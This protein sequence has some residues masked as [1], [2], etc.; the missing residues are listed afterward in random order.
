M[1]TK[2]QALTAREFHFTGMHDCIR[3]V[4]PRGGV[5]VNVTVARRNGQTKTW[6]TRPEEFSVPVKY[7]E[8]SWV[9]GLYGHAYVDHDNA[10]D[11]HTREDCLIA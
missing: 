5:T 6:V 8:Q 2:Q 4:G 3:K 10:S 7:V 1:I 9:H 11:W